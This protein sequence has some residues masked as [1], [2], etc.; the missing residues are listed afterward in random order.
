MRVSETSTSAT[1]GK[2]LADSKVAQAFPGLEENTMSVEKKTLY[3]RLGG[4][5]AITAVAT[6]LR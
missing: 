2:N 6:I 5:N 3:E 4:Y 1:Q